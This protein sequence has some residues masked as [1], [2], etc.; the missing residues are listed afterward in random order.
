MAKQRESQYTIRDLA[1][2]SRPLNAAFV[3]DLRK[4][5][6]AQVGQIVV[7]KDGI[8]VGAE[9]YQACLHEGVVPSITILPYD[10]DPIEFQAR[11]VELLESSGKTERAYQAFK[12]WEMLQNWEPEELP[13]RY[14]NLRAQWGQKRL[15]KEFGVSLRMLSDAS[16]VFGGDSTAVKEVREA[17]RTG[18]LKLYGAASL[19]TL[20]AGMQRRAVALIAS[21]SAGTAKKAVQLIKLNEARAAG[22]SAREEGE[23]T[24]RLQLH[25]LT[26]KDLQR[27]MPAESVDMVLTF[28]SVDEDSWQSV[29]DLIPFGAH[30]LKLD[31]VMAVIVKP[32]D[33][34]KVAE[35]IQEEVGGLEF[36]REVVVRFEAQYEKPGRLPTVHLGHKSVLVFA[37]RQFR[38][39]DME[40][41]FARLSDE[42]M[43]EADKG[44]QET[45]RNIIHRTVRRMP[46]H[47]WTICDPLLA[48]HWQ[49]AA[50]ALKDPCTFI[51]A[52]QDQGCLDIVR[53]RL[54]EEGHISGTDTQ[55]S[56][57]DSHD[58]SQIPLVI[59]PEAGGPV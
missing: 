54:M 16:R 52:C 50:A 53:G 20:D 32:E 39:T 41:I 3:R 9:E 30:V 14:A 38:L 46:K 59:F 22:K 1:E 15:A 49:I 23:I 17:V 26:I 33:V 51:G 13:E 27:Q 55:P 21:K 36:R 29:C 2:A 44:L 45:A 4:G 5:A 6:K 10:A 58:Q 56:H 7:W 8:I 42:E 48:D 19:S 57:S 12:T 24:S 40:V 25:A 34:L 43:R 37:K 31:G 11:Q 28:P 18:L 47:D 35:L